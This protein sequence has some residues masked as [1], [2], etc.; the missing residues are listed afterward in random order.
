MI[1]ASCAATADVLPTIAA[2]NSPALVCRRVIMIFSLCQTAVGSTPRQTRLSNIA[3]LSASVSDLPFR[4]LQENYF[5]LHQFDVDNLIAVKS[6]L[7]LVLSTL[8][9]LPSCAR[10]EILDLPWTHE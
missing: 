5:D 2:D 4:S 8:P 3:N 9:N 7:I 10:S 6:F 1:D